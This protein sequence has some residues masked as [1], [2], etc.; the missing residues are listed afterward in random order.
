[1]R[2]RPPGEEE[3]RWMGERIHRA[4]GERWF[5]LLEDLIAHNLDALFPGLTVRAS[6]CF[7][8]TRDA[9]LDLQEDEADDLLAAIESELRKRR[10]G[11]PVRLEVE[12]GMPEALRD[13]LLDALDLQPLDCYEIDGI[14]ATSDVMALA[15]LDYPD[16]RDSVFTPSIPK[17]LVG[18]TDLFAVIREGDL[19]LHHPYDSFS[20]VVELLN[21]AA[22]DPGV[23]AIKQSLYRVGEHAPVVDALLDAAQ[24]G[25]QV[26][27]SAELTACGDESSNFDCARLLERAAV[28]VA[29]GLTRL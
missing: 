10:F 20:C 8:V 24:H 21:T 1:M 25:K 27:V 9:D 3:V 23:L 19:L 6:Y 4:E 29:Y 28:H 15:G 16:L 12:A 13:F 22:R 2:E 18:V 5:V 26:A 11:E 7:R 17:R 14:L